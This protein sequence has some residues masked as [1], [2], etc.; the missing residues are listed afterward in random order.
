MDVRGFVRAY[1]TPLWLT[2]VFVLLLLVF[3]I[4]PDPDT[5]RGA[6]EPTSEPTP[7]PHE[8]V[9]CPI[10]Q[11]CDPTSGQCLFVD[12]TPLPC[13]K[14]AKFDKKAGFCLPEGA[15]PAP[16]AATEPAGRVPG[17]PRFPGGIGGDQP[18]DPDLPGFGND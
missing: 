6:G 12:H 11:K 16:A 5:A 14:S 17:A 1:R 7:G 2:A 18:R 3:A 15:P 9:V 8:C 4:T 13:V 10:D